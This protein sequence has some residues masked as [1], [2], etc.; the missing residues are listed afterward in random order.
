MTREEAK[1]WIKKTCGSG[2][3]HLIDEVYDKLPPNVNV[4]AVYQ[5]WAF[6]RFDLDKED[7]V[8]EKFLEEIEER[9]SHVCEICGE[10]GSNML[11]NGWERTRCTQHIKT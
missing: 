9:S 4:E 10:T 1:T 7:D 3:L 11:I 6:L 5:K 2:W 8:F